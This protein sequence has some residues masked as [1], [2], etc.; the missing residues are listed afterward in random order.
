MDW[1]SLGLLGIFIAVFLSY[2]FLPISSEL[3]I[4]PAVK[5]VNPWLL[6]L[7]AIIAATLGSLLN[8]Y[9]GYKGIRKLMPK[10]HKLKK[11]EKFFSKYG[12]FAVILLSWLPYIGDPLIIVAGTFRMP[13]LRFLFASTIAKGW[14][15]TL[16]IFFGLMLFA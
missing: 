14:Y 7:I 3:S 4:I 10:K 9:I 8:Y 13:L 12:L 6:F 15:L 11:A 5:M 1:L 2:S 16:L